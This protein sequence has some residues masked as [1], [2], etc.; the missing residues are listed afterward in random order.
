MDDKPIEEM[1][2]Q[3]L[4]ECLRESGGCQDEALARL[5][6]ADAKT[7]NFVAAQESK[8]RDALVEGVLAYELFNQKSKASPFNEEEFNSA[9]E[10][11]SRAIQKALAMISEGEKHFTEPYPEVV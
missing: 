7:H 8:W 10:R 2:N 9:K 6:E 4:A 11:L 3:E 1:T 5:L